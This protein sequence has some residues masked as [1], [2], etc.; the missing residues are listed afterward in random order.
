MPLALSSFSE[1]F[2]AIEACER[3]IKISGLHGASN[4]LLLSLL[5]KE[6]RSFCLVAPSQPKAERA[7]KNLTFFFA[8]NGIPLNPLFFPPWDVLPHERTAPRTDWIARRLSVLHQLAQDD[9]FC[10]VTS[11]DGL[12]QK[13]MPKSRFLDDASLLSVGSTLDRETL[14]EQLHRGHYRRVETV[15]EPGEMAVRGG[16]VDLFSPLSPQPARLEFMGDTL[17]AIRLFDPQSQRS[18]DAMTSIEIIP[19]TESLDPRT[20]VSLADYFPLTTLWVVDEPDDVIQQGTRYCERVAESL[21]SETGHLTGAPPPAA[22]GHPSFFPLTHLDDAGAGRTV[23][24]IERLSLR[25][26]PGVRRLIFDASSPSAL[27]LGR[28]GETISVI[29]EHLNLLR[30][31]YRILLAARGNVQISRI[32]RL[33]SEQG[34]SWTPWPAGPIAMTFPS[35]VYLASGDLSGGFCLPKEK[36]IVLNEEEFTGRS[37]ARLRRKR[38]GFQ[39]S[40]LSSFQDVKPLDPVVHLNHGI[41]RYVGLKQIAVRQQEAAKG[42]AT[43]FFVIE[44][45]G[46]DKVY[47][48]LDSLHLVQR[49]TGADGEKPA[50]DRLGGT[51]WAKAKAQTSKKIEEMMEPLLALYAERQLVSGH[52]FSEPTA[53]DAFVAL[54]EYEETPDQLRSIEEVLADMRLPKPMDRLVCGDVGF[55]KTEVAMR[56]AFCAVMDNKQVALLAPTTLLAHQHYASFSRRF[57]PFPVRVE[58]ISRFRSPQE[59]RKIIADL[60]SG[61]IDVLIGTH[62]ILQKDVQFPNLGL[63]VVDEEHRFGVRHKEWLKEVR[64]QV[65]VLTLTATPIPRTLHMALSAVRDLSVIETAPANRLPIQTLLAPFDP[66]IIRDAISRELVRGGQIFFVHNR[67]HNIE[68][69][70]NFLAGLVPE[71][72]IGIAHGQMHEQRLEEVILK[73]IAGEY[74]LLLTTTI[75]E[76]GIDI[77]NANTIIINNADH[78]GLAELYQLRGR[79]GRAGEQAYAYLLVQEER[80]LTD[81]AQQRLRAV[82]EFTELGSGFKIAA[83]DLEIRGAGNLLGGE[84]SG[85]VAAVG[86]ELYLKM[87]EERVE[88]MR[89]K[90]PAPEVETTVQFH[91]PALLPESYISDIGSRL[92]IYKRI[93]TSVG[94][95]ELDELQNEMVDRFGTLPP[96]ATRLLDVMRIKQMAKRARVLKVIEKEG[97]VSFVFEGSA[98][99]SHHDPL[100]LTSRYGRR[101]RFISDYAFEI[102][103]AT[104]TWD[105]IHRETSSCLSFLTLIAGAHVAPRGGRAPHRAK[106]E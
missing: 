36:W 74:T 105:E 80:I 102:T 22:Q 46:G 67:V 7:Y 12:L 90:L 28:P 48:P 88:Q 15:T 41:G 89:G 10:V 77:P 24:E 9:R 87:V 68:Q 93:S 95:E 59:Q 5:A 104:S 60:K 26:E 71:A 42:I 50:L 52:A 8:I 76:S 38:S 94:A 78:F 21:R 101:L 6:G 3:K 56:A 79:V 11:I 1:L 17:E 32:G 58:V 70:G 18:V 27:G 35:P 106:P 2:S 30:K 4:A 31:D 103:M 82:Q 97:A 40:F 53:L 75:I 54:F 13:V 19:A 65:D 92:L 51:R 69:I 62:R 85:A 14:I 66:A 44:Y 86:F 34:L 99:V 84:Q 20:S 91:A 23:I 81:E 73:F 39:D 43:D 33:L 100:K 45:A 37:A 96:E 47:V 49:Y 57:A 63:V 16:I 61:V 98:S 29:I 25:N 55:G 72:K 83:R 64:K